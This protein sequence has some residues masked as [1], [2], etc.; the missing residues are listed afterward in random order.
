[1]D[2]DAVV[3][4]YVRCESP[5]APVNPRLCGFTRVNVSAGEKKTVSLQ[6][7]RLT[8]TVVN[9]QGERV[10][11]ESLTLYVGLSQPDKKSIGLC[12]VQPVEI[13]G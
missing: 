6:L 11:S 1:M 9:E 8:D 7:D 10:K 4:V 3:Q 13:K 2:G 12:G 5:Y